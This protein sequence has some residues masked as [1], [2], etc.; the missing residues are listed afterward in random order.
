[1]KTKQTTIP[2]TGAKW[3]PGAMALAATAASSHAATVQITLSGNKISTNSAGGNSLNADLTGDGNNE[4][5]LFGVSATANKA[6]LQLFINLYGGMIMGRASFDARA[7]RF[8]AG[9][10]YSRLDS[11]MRFSSSAQTMVELLPLRFRDQRINGGSGTNGWLEVTAFNNSE[12][13]HTVQLT[14]LIFDNASTNVPNPGSISSVQTEWSP[15]VIP[16]PSSFALLGLG[17]AGLVA[18]RRRQAA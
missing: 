13:S 5:D 11:A 1:M 3:L 6:E 10:A 4:L 15:N 8:G 2:R 16:E 17:A 9:V 14:R 18:R 7:Q 12:T